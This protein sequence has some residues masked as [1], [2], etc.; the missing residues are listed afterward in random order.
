MSTVYGEDVFAQF[1]RLLDG[2]TEMAT[3]SDFAGEYGEKAAAYL[4]NHRSV[5][6]YDSEEISIEERWVYDAGQEFSSIEEKASR[7]YLKP[8]AKAGA[9][10]S[11]WAA[12]TF[13]AAENGDL[14]LIGLS[15]V[16]AFPAWDGVKQAHQEIRSIK[17]DRRYFSRLEDM[18]DSTVVEKGVEDYE[19]EVLDPLEFSDLV[20]E[21]GKDGVD[22]E[23][24][25]RVSS[26]NLFLF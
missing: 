17:D 5:W 1:D 11:P 9:K 7:S 23:V 18:Y 13:L 19:L 15:Q 25:H 4:L 12:S 26:V 8:V 6:N 2:E 16:F 3:V 24:K 21:V 10:A 14:A 20:D 22:A